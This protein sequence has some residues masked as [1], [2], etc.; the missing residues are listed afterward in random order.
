MKLQAAG[1]SNSN[2]NPGVYGGAGAWLDQTLTV[3]AGSTLMIVVGTA[4]SFQSAGNVGFVAS[5][6]GSGARGGGG[7]GG[8][9]SGVLLL[10]PARIFTALG[11]AGGGGAGGGAISAGGDGGAPN[12]GNASVQGGSGGTT[13]AGG[14][15]DYTAPGANGAAGN[16]GVPWSTICGGWGVYDSVGL[17]GSGGGGGGYY[18]GGSG[19][20]TDVGPNQGAGGGGSSYVNPSAW[21]VLNQAGTTTTVPAASAADPDFLGAYG[22]GAANVGGQGRVVLIV[23]GVKYLY[24]VNGS[25]G[26]NGTA[27]G[28]YPYFLTI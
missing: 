9:L 12:G 16:A 20:S 11:I 6:F 10:T 4:A 26:I 23:D 3:P 14:A 7:A 8:G 21:N 28:C 24:D 17:S 19:T 18:G 13:S 27:A 1:G 15:G 22:A 2:I 5:F 25:Y